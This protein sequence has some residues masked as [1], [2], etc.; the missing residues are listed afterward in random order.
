MPALKP[1]RSPCCTNTAFSCFTNPLA[2]PRH[3][4][5]M[6]EPYLILHP[7]KAVA[8]LSSTT[9][10]S[11]ERRA[12]PPP[13]SSLVA[14]GV[15]LAG[16]VASTAS[17]AR[18]PR[19]ALARPTDPLVADELV[20]HV[21]ALAGAIGVEVVGAVGL[22]GVEEPA[23][24]RR[25]SRKLAIKVRLSTSITASASGRAGCPCGLRIA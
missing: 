22:T 11:S 25:L 8:P 18:S 19:R 13:E 12:R 3:M 5:S 23:S 15:A 9:A 20:A 6:N 2:T 1:W 24:L 16:I 7:G 17:M 21:I 4:H 10:R 14:L